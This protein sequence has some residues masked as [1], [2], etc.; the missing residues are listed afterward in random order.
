M[1]PG[2]S[3]EG[4]ILPERTGHWDMQLRDGKIATL[5]PSATSGGGM[6]LPVMADIHTHLD[7]TFTARR[8]PRRAQ[9][10]F[11][12]IDMMATD[13]AGWTPDDIRKRAEKGLA[14]A[15]GHGT[16]LMRSHLDWTS[17]T[18]PPAWSVLRDLA[19]EWQGRI[20]LELASLSPLEHLVE[21]GTRIAAELGPAGGV[22]GAFIYRND[23][24]ENGLARVFDLAE[25]YDLRLD[26]HVDEGLEPEARGFDA[27]LRQTEQRGL[28]G[29]VLCG[30]CCALSVR[31]TAEVA[32][33]LARA[34]E[35]GMGLVTLPACN[36]YLQD[37]TSGRTPRLRGIAPIQEARASG[38]A[39]MIGSDNVQDGFHPY[40]D[41]DL[42]NIWHLA[43]LLGHLTPADWLDAI[44]GIPA[45]WMGHD[46][47][48][49]EGGPADFI[50]I[51]AATPEEMLCHPGVARQVWRQGRPLNTGGLQ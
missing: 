20:T 34:A 21:H 43:V 38:M 26:F 24:L 44:S 48:L 9:S 29:R 46:L 3:L 11:D 30:H 47:T 22:L 45:W 39:V 41:Y 35:A 49:R 36:A 6:V 31:D 25:R 42:L 2:T 10:L 13:A 12:A 32:S 28:S 18:P 27:I 37:A 5:R 50:H 17:D 16:A 19:E 51:A 1:A 40:G 14:R 4:V 8:M 23:N 15:Y 7:K 33:L